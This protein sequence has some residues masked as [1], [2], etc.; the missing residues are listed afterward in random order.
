MSTSDHVDEAPWYVFMQ[1]SN[2]KDGS[3]IKFGIIYIL[4]NPANPNSNQIKSFYTQIYL[5][6]SSR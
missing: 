6:L 4:G 5:V 3:N 2:K 1:G